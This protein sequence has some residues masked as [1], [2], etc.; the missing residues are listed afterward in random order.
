MQIFSSLKTKSV[1]ATH[2]QKKKPLSESI[3]KSIKTIFYSKY[4]FIKGYWYDKKIKVPNVQ[5]MIC[6]KSNWYRSK[7]ADLPK[8]KYE[9]HSEIA[10]FSGNIGGIESTNIRQK[11]N[12]SWSFYLPTFDIEKVKTHGNSATKNKFLKMDETKFETLDL[13]VEAANTLIQKLKTVKEKALE[14]EET[15]PK[16]ITISNSIKHQT[17]LGTNLD[18]IDTNLSTKKDFRV[19]D[20]VLIGSDFEYNFVSEFSPIILFSINDISLNIPNKIETSSIDTST[21]SDINTI[22]KKSKT[23]YA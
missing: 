4:S 7:G 13:N 8:Y 10:E 3:A 17:N 16:L 20:L 2:P 23:K 6:G 5:F 1:V 15:K 18:I 21:L 22:S 14:I 12:I 19:A 9:I 11:F